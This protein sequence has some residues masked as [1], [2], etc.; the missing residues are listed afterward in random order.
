[1]AERCGRWRLLL[2]RR[3]QL[4]HRERPIVLLGG[5]SVGL[6][7]EDA[8]AGGGLAMRA[9]VAPKRV[10]PLA[11]TRERLVEHHP[12]RR[13][14]A[15]LA[16]LAQDL[17]ERPREPWRRCEGDGIEVLRDEIDELVGHGVP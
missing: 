7:L 3:A 10:E 14:H 6:R 17:A 4:E 15:V 1:M 9:A 13:A 12:V 16:D 2:R 5:Q 8:A 11:A